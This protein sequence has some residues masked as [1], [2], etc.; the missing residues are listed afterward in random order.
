MGF[1]KQLVFLACKNKTEVKTQKINVKKV[2]K[3][4]TICRDLAQAPC[5]V[6]LQKCLHENNFKTHENGKTLLRKVFYST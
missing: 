3:P 1:L 5:K 2:Q 4:Y 6:A